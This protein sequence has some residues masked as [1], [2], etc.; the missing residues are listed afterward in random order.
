MGT[1]PHPCPHPCPHPGPH[2]CPHPGPHPIPGPRPLDKLC[3]SGR[4]GP[5]GRATKPRWVLGT[6][7]WPG[8]SLPASDVCGVFRCWGLCPVPCPVPGP[9]PRAEGPRSQPGGS[10]VTAG[11]VPGHSPA[12]LERKID[13]GGTTG[14]GPAAG[15]A[16]AAPREGTEA[17]KGQ[18]I[19]FAAGTEGTG[20]SGRERDRGHFTDNPKPG[21]PSRAARPGG[22]S[23]GGDRAGQTEPVSCPASPGTAERASAVPGPALSSQG[24]PQHSPGDME[25]L[26]TVRERQLRPLPH[27]TGHTGLG[28]AEPGTD[29]PQR[30]ERSP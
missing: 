5:T 18:R 16:T 26:G 19:P 30:G 2:P 29:C 24:S 20:R 14:S 25:P 3:F 4:W 7:S 1:R 28:T 11:R 8:N 23:A 22:R 13:H 6:C 21:D 17:P 10:P 15:P 12:L 9:F 27:P